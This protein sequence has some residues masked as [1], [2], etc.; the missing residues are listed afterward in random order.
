MR[1][2]E[3]KFVDI[4]RDSQKSR[5]SRCLLLRAAR[6]LLSNRCANRRHKGGIQKVSVKSAS[7]KK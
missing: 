6:E 2:G 7:I 3:M 5:N 1:G 4:R